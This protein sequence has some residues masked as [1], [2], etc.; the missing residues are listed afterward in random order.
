MSDE[1]EARSTLITHYSLLLITHYLFLV[2]VLVFVLVVS[3]LF[4]DIKLDG[5]ES[6][7]LKLG[8]ALFTINHLAF[9]R[10]SIDMNIGIAFWARSGR[11]FF[12]L[13]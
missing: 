10:V 11:H 1:F 7:N 4:H 9:V 2:F 5:I 3:F 6:H 8:S 13:Q 12:H